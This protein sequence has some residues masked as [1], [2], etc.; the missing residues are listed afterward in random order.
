MPVIQNPTEV[1]R[2]IEQ[3]GADEYARRTTDALFDF[4]EGSRDWMS[5]D[6]ALGAEAGQQAWARVRDGAVAPSVGC[7]VSM[8]DRAADRPA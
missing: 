2:R 8:H 5:I 7:I 1:A 3:W 4:V 6:T